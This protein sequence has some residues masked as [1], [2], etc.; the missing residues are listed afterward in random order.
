[1]QLKWK[2]QQHKN[3]F[4]DE[5]KN[6]NPGETKDQSQK[7]K[8]EKTVSIKLRSPVFFSLAS[9]GFRTFNRLKAYSI[10]LCSDVQIHAFH[11]AIPSKAMS[12][13]KTQTLSFNYNPT[14]ELKGPVCKI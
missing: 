11:E 14:S 13:Q 3:V 10:V 7:Q 2:S 5:K 6:N 9:W 8:E 12:S 4:P 1:M